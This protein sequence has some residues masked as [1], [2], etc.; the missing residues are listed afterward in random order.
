MLTVGSSKHKAR[1]AM[2]LKCYTSF[3]K[4]CMLATIALVTLAACQQEKPAVPVHPPL[5]VG[6]HTWPGYFPIAL[7]AQRGL[8]AKH[9]VAVETMLYESALSS[10]PDLLAGKIDG[11][12]GTLADALLMDGRLP[13]NV[14]VVLVADSSAGGDVVV[15]TP[16]IATVADLQGKRVG[17]R[18]GSFSELFVLTMLRMNHLTKADVTLLKVEPKDVPTAIP[19]V[20]Q[21]GHTWGQGISQALAKGNHIIFSSSDTPGLILDLV[22][23]RTKVIETRPDDIRAFIAAWLEAVDYWRAHPTEG[24]TAIAEV[25]GMQRGQLSTA[26]LKLFNL[27]DNLQAFTPGVDTTSLSVSSEVNRAFLINS[28]GLTSAPVL[29]RL[30]D[31]SFVHTLHR[32]LGK[33]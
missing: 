25:T 28:G 24:N 6:W 32:T 18:L 16:D 10:H 22:I 5:K 2:Q 4:L 8:F 1:I 12:T 19:E 17:A 15:A 9:G 20:I 30:L 23:F 27:Q 14:R 33:Q 26:G 21:A 7:A 31:G 3:S 13:D 11:A 29:E